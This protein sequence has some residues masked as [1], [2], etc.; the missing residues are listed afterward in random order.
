[1][2]SSTFPSTSAVDGE[3]EVNTTPWRLY[4]LERPDIQCKGGWVG[5]V[6]SLEGWGKSRPP[7]GFDLPTI[8]SIA[9]HYTYCTNPTPGN[10]IGQ[11]IFSAGTERLNMKRIFRVARCGSANQH[12][13]M[14]H[15]FCVPLHFLLAV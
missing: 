6:A 5:P 3:W 2:Y 7:L 14:V 10:K 9:S 11:F 8:P 13:F 12:S 4:P 1:M 15:A